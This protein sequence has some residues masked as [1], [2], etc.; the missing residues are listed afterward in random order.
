MKSLDHA[1]VIQPAELRPRHRA[2][3]PPP[4]ALSLPSL[5]VAGLFLLLVQF[6]DVPS[7]GVLTEEMAADVVGPDPVEV[8]API[9]VFVA[10]ARNHE[11]VETERSKAPRNEAARYCQLLPKKDDERNCGIIGDFDGAGILRR[12][13]STMP[14]SLPYGGSIASSSPC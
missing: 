2:R 13:C 3:C 9:A 12:A 5:L 10:H 14:C 11:D 7:V 8:G 6:D 4:S 1:V